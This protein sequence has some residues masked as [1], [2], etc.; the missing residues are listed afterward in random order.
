MLFEHIKALSW[1][2]K[3]KL[4]HNET[5]NHVIDVFKGI[6]NPRIIG[7][8]TRHIRETRPAGAGYNTSCKKRS[9]H[10]CLNLGSRSFR[11]P[12]HLQN[13][14]DRHVNSLTKTVAFHSGEIRFIPYP[15]H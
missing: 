11:H 10:V 14:K 2:D 9:R 4:F 15:P 13:G 12:L 6:E 3:K 7:L 1:I 8:I 5:N